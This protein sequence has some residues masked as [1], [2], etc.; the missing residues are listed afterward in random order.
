[1]EVQ[2]PGFGEEVAA[3]AEPMRRNPWSRRSVPHPPAP[4]DAPRAGT[5]V[6]QTDALRKRFEPRVAG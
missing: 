6:R 2:S 5:P 4:T 1:V 3:E